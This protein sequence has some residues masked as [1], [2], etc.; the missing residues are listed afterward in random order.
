[1]SVDR[2]LLARIEA[3]EHAFALPRKL[4][5]LRC[6]HCDYEV[7][8]LSRRR[9]RSPVCPRCGYRALAH[10]ATVE[11]PAPHHDDEGLA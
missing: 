7:A 3:L 1:V 6:G 8:E 9:R 5:L 10:A 2:Q 11:W 4:P